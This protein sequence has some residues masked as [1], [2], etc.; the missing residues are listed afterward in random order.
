[1]LHRRLGH[2]CSSRAGDLPPTINL[3]SHQNDIR[4]VD[5]PSQQ[6]SDDRLVY[7]NIARSVDA[8]P[9]QP[10]VVPSTAVLAA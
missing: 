5:Q 6:T 7:H 8:G 1:L 3:R 9:I 2:S 10:I 4:A